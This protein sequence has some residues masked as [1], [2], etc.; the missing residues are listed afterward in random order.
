[1]KKILIQLPDY[2]YLHI[3]LN[4]LIHKAVDKNCRLPLEPLDAHF[5][6]ESRIY[7]R[8]FRW[9][10]TLYRLVRPKKLLFLAIDGVA[11]RAKFNTQRRR[12]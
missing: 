2:E 12:R 3:D 11:P 5:Y 6:D 8:I 1:M 10:E 7:E 9:I 4:F